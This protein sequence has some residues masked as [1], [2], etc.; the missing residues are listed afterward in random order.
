MALYLVIQ[1]GAL[2][3]RVIPRSW[4][5]VIGSAI[6]D[7]VYLL[8]WQKR[9]ILLGNSS[10]VVGTAT[11]D[12]AVRSLARRS[13]R[14]YFKYLVEFLEL[15]IRSS[16]DDVIASMNIRGVEHLQAALER[17]KGV[18]VASAHFGTIETGGLRLADFTDL[19]AVYDTFRPPYL[20][21]L[22]QSKR[23]EKGIHLVPVDNVREMMRVL[24]RGGALT[25]L[26]DRPLHAA[27][28][29][30]VHFFGRDTYVP[31]GPAVLAMKTGA[32]LLPVYMLR[33]PDKTFESVIF[34]PVTWTSTGQRS[35]DVQAIMQRLMDTLQTMIRERPDQWYMF[36][37][38]WPE[39]REIVGSGRR[40]S[41]PD[42]PGTR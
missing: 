17:G 35:R 37:P 11:H 42:R 14:N 9:R 26:F 29:V 18:I 28:G 32:T 12:P 10:V 6:G 2:L 31:A 33:N 15:P 23:L 41:V 4:R 3:S 1:I 39:V 40:Q 24:R 16:S 22:I 36:R 21:R 34:P 19:H 7:L 38:M 30:R 8:M 25:M 20:D 27:K 13:F 5:Y